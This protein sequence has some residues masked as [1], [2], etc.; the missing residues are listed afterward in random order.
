[1]NENERLCTGKQGKQLYHNNGHQ[2]NVV[3]EIGR[4]IVELD[5][6]LRESNK[7]G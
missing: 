7:N 4:H 3:E 1:M 6:E 5:K 2:V